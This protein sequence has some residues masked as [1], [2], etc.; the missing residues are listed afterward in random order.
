MSNLDY[1]KLA[2]S[3]LDNKEARDLIV[4]ELIEELKNRN[5][6]NNWFK[7]ISFLISLITLLTSTI[8][9]EKFKSWIQ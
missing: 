3:L 7:L 1:N 5:A 2:K 8:L 9:M 6:A 4:E